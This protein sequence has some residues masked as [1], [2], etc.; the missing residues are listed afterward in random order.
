MGS[1]IGPQNVLIT[2]PNTGL[3]CKSTQPID[4][5]NT[6]ALCVAESIVDTEHVGLRVRYMRDRTTSMKLTST[7]PT[8]SRKGRYGDAPWSRTRDVAANES[9]W[10]WSTGRKNITNAVRNEDGAGL[11]RQELPI[12][13]ARAWQ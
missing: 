9:R 2:L 12:G 10:R 5:E 1:Q 7:A 8:C 6:S 3:R 11:A 4:V 13:Q